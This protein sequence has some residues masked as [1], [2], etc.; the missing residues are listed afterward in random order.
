MRRAGWLL[1]LALNAPAWG[2]AEAPAGAL[3]T[4]PETGL[5][6]WLET[7]PNEAGQTVMLPYVKTLHPLQVRASVSVVT[8]GAAGNARASQQARL[9]VPAGQATLLARLTLGL[10]AND[11]CRMDVVLHDLET[12]REVARYRINCHP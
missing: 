11:E 10:A 7:Q 12:S 4:S 1:A 6:V 2:V 3:A 8:K 9:E 5:Q